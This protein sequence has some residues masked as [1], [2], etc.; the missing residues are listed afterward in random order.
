MSTDIRKRRNP[1]PR[2]LLLIILLL[3]GIWLVYTYLIAPPVPLPSKLN[4]ISSPASSP[5]TQPPP[6]H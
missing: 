3:A 5:P 1:I 4:I 2:L 6:A